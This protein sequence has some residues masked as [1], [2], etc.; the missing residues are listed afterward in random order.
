MSPVNKYTQEAV[1]EKDIVKM[2]DNLA[3]GESVSI[4]T[5]VQATDDAVM[6]DNP[7]YDVTNYNIP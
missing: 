5:T 6:Q 1:N 3:Y 4:Q 7:A 2:E